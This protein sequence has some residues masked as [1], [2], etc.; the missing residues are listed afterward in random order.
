MVYD[1]KRENDILIDLLKEGSWVAKREGNPPPPGEHPPWWP[2]G[3]SH[4]IDTLHRR[5]VDRAAPALLKVLEEKGPGQG[6]PAEQ[7]IPVLVDFKYKRA[8]P[9]LERMVASKPAPHGRRPYALVDHK[10][11]QALAIKALV[12]L[13]DDGK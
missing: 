1:E 7:I 6:Y 4:I 8:I 9:E 13:K 3:R 12:K 5:K 10:A 2:D 11:V